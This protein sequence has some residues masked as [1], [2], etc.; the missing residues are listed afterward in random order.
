MVRLPHSAL[1][2][3]PGQPG[4]DGCCTERYYRQLHEAGCEVFVLGNSGLFGKDKA[5]TRHALQLCL[6]ALDRELEE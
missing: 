6:E 5:D 4:R 2:G 1:P 3:S